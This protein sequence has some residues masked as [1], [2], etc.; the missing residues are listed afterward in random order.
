MQSTNQSLTNQKINS[1]DSIIEIHESLVDISKQG[2]F[3]FVDFIQ[4]L[5]SI[6][7]TEINTSDLQV[8]NDQLSIY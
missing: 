6:E 4:Y 1:N 3:I 5:I 7:S 8:S 2:L